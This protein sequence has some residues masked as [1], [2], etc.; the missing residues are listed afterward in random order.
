MKTSLRVCLALACVGAVTALPGCGG[1]S[2]FFSTNVSQ[3]AGTYFGTFSGVTAQGAPG[4]GQTVSGTFTAVADSAGKVTGSFTQ[5]GLGTFPSTGTISPSG[6][7]T[8]TALIGNQTA[9]LNGKITLGSGN[10]G[11]VS[12]IFTTTQ[13]GTTG[14]IGMTLV[15][16]TFS[17]TRAVQDPP[18]A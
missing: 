12:G 4:A 11:T 6:A 5:S 15:R 9:S 3:Y 17:G 7:I 2:S 14:Q 1:G 10:Q 18:V 8:V 16:G 13:Q